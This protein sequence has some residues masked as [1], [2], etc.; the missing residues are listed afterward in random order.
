MSNM[1]QTREPTIK[2]VYDDNFLSEI[3]KINNLI[4]Q[5]P[6]VSM[7]KFDIF[8]ILGHRISRNSIQNTIPKLL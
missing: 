7:V 3:K 8:Y 2:E 5:F 1:Q 4:D 6:Y